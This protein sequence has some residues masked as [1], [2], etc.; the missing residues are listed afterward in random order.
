MAHPRWH[1]AQSTAAA[2]AGA[3][4]PEQRTKLPDLETMA[5]IGAITAALA[6]ATG[7]LTINT[8]LHHLGI[9]D[10]SLVKP[11]L[12]LTGT[13]VLV[14]LLL[15]ALFPLYVTW[16]LVHRSEHKAWFTRRLFLLLIPLAGLFAISAY[17]CFP[18]R[19][20]LGQIGVREAWHTINTMGWQRS[21]FTALL[22]TLLLTFELYL[23]A[24]GVSVFAVAALKALDRV[25]LVPPTSILRTQWIEFLLAFSATAI[26]GV[27]YLG[28]FG[29]TLYPAIPTQ[30]GGGQPVYQRIEVD[31]VG[32]AQLMQL[33]VA[34]D[35][36]TNITCALPVMHDSDTLL[37]VWLQRPNTEENGRWGAV[38]LQLDKK[39]IGASM[40]FPGD[41]GY[42]MTAARGAQPGGRL[43]RAA[44]A[45]PITANSADQKTASSGESQAN[46]NSCRAQS[47]TSA[48][49]GGAGPK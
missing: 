20:G 6:F 11:K 19:I 25:R 38:V 21:L 3:E 15:L 13:L 48:T 4:P 28:A 49:A 34:F 24:V 16:Q 10:F 17:L 36:D 44:N 43:P 42:Q 12:I 9:T 8:Y 39:Q 32:R 31:N 47:T 5:K 33:G 46:A 1:V 30:F 40:V 26:C 41:N 22:T 35:G 37:A 29:V 14:S 18:T 27:W 7:T 2:H 23:P 45:A